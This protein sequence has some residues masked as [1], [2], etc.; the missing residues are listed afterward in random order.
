M[1]LLIPS[2]TLAALAL[3]AAP[4]A[5]L[6]KADRTLRKEPAYRGK[7]QYCL[8]VF[9]PGA[10]ETAWLVLDLVSEPWDA[11]GERDALYVD[12]DGSGDLT[13]PGKRVAVTM[14]SGQSI[15]RFSHRE[16]TWY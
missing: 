14:R 16:Y 2:L 11:R 5:D 12:R 9:G 8:L 6:A 10:R 4:A 13:Q 15:D 7:P 3:G 1:R